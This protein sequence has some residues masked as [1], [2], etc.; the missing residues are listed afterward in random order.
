MSGI[1][2]ADLNRSDADCEG[3]VY[4]QPPSAEKGAAKERI[5]KRLQMGERNAASLEDIIARD[6]CET[7]GKE[8]GRIDAVLIGIAGQT[9]SRRR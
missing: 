4:R 7:A 1:R 9:A 8:I 6:P 2:Y 5:E 3:P